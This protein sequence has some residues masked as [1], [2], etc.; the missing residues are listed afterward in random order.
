MAFIKYTN[1]QLENLIEQTYSGSVNP[2]RL[3]PDLYSAIVSRLMSAVK[4]GM[5]LRGKKTFTD[6][7]PDDLLFRYFQNNIALFSGAKTFQQ[8][9]D[10]S[11]LVFKSDG[12]KRDFSEFK[13]LIKGD[14]F[15]EGIFNKYNDNWLRTEFDTSF[16]LAQTGREWNGIVEDAD[17][18]PYLKYITVSDERV[19]QDHREF[20]GVTLPVGHSWWNSH[21]PTNGFNCRCRVIQLSADDDGLQVTTTDELNDI[22]PVDPSLFAF[23][24]GKKGFI[25]DP[26]K[27][28]YFTKIAERYQAQK[29]VNFGLPTPPKPVEPIVTP[30]LPNPRLKPAT[31]PKP[32]KSKIQ[33]HIEKV[34][35]DNFDEM[36]IEMPNEFWSVIPT[37][38]KSLTYVSQRARHVDGDIYLSTNVPRARHT[39]KHAKKSITAHEFGH[40]SHKQTGELVPFKQFAPEIE[41]LFVDSRNAVQMGARRNSK[42]YEIKRKF[43]LKMYQLDIDLRGDLPAIL[44]KFPYLKG[45]NQREIMEMKGTIFDYIGSLSLGKH[46][47]GHAIQYYKRAGGYGA[48]AEMFAESFENYFVGNPLFENELPELFKLSTDYV[49]NYIKRHGI[50]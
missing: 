42:N 29:D 44:E 16:G 47:G 27:H 43:L 35:P 38:P 28:P 12:F 26:N 1:E 25:F 34:K 8:I 2:S 21:Y 30:K 32:K 9:N 5:G 41:K 49:K 11:N 19:R 4:M 10:M 31:K 13:R 50:N 36:G 20:N 37:K 40:F 17:I 24:P 33:Q 46:G 14:K 48:R 6:G 23:N 22:P 39:T 7:S 3:P 15:H 18:L 45:Y